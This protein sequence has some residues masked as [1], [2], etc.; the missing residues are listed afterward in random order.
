MHINDKFYYFL[1]KNYFNKYKFSAT[2]KIWQE[3]VFS[4]ALISVHSEKIKP[5]HEKMGEM[6]IC[7][8]KMCK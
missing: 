2:L 6:C 4:N 5:V 1:Y 7:L 8:L 3:G